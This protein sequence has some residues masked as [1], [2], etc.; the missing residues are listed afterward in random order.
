[1]P[2]KSRHE[3]DETLEDDD[4]PGSRKGGD[5]D[6]DADDDDEDT[7]DLDTAEEEEE[8]DDE[9]EDDEDDEEK[10]VVSVDDLERRKVFQ[11]EAEEILEH[12]TLD[13]IKEVLSENEQETSLAPKLRKFLVEVIHEGE[14]ENM[15][16][17]WEEALDRLEESEA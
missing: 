11:S 9:E 7:I 10:A 1:L 6:D 4:A 8:D 15:D 16:D 12:L 13:D 14:V 17:A 2:R 3:D 5:D